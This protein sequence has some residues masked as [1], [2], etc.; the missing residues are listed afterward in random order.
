VKDKVEEIVISPLIF[1]G[2]WALIL[3]Q[4][5]SDYG[6]EKYKNCHQAK[7]GHPSGQP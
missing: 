6:I 4:L 5:D 1:I 3:V 2:K 7:K